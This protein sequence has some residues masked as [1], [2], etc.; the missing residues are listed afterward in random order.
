MEPFESM[1]LSLLFNGPMVLYYTTYESPDLIDILC[2]MNH[3]KKE[4]FKKTVR[5]HLATVIVTN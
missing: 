1:S 2:K 3:K 4:L 5:C